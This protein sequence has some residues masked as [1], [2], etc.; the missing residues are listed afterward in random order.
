VGAVLNV[1]NAPPDRVATL[2]EGGPV[3]WA[4]PV[5]DD[6]GATLD[7]IRDAGATWAV[8]TPDAD[9]EALARWRQP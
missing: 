6:L 1:W 8:L 3:S 4:G 5:P 7:A 9:I 2:G